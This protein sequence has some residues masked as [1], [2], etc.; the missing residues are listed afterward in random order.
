MPECA[1]GDIQLVVEAFRLPENPMHE[2][3]KYGEA[4]FNVFPRRGALFSAVR[5][6][7]PS[8]KDSSELY[9]FETNITLSQVQEGEG[10]WTNCGAIRASVKLKYEE[11]EQTSKSLIC[12]NG[13]KF[14]DR[15]QKMAEV[16]TDWQIYYQQMI[17]NLLQFTVVG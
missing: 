5:Q 8:T 11:P 3:D 6:K 10:F 9:Q 12:S 2:G 17:Q 4:V 7:T 15:I 13:E 16:E 14:Y 1:D